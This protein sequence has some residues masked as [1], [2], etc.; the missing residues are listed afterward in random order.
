MVSTISADHAISG[1]VSMSGSSAACVSASSSLGAAWCWL[2]LAFHHPTEKPWQT[3]P[4]KSATALLVSRFE[5]TCWWQKSWASHPACC[6]KRPSVT[7]E[8]SASSRLIDDDGDDD[9]EEE[10]LFFDKNSMATA[11]AASE[12]VD[13]TLKQ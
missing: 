2:C 13:A 10:E 12:S 11:V 3:F 8:A 9:G 7:A 6:Q 1:S 4:R 5:K